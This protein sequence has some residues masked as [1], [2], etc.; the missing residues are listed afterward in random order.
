MSL[1]WPLSRDGNLSF[2]FTWGDG[3]IEDRAKV[4][5]LPLFE[6]SMSPLFEGSSI[7]NN[8]LRDNS[9][10]TKCMAMQTW[11]EIKRQDY[12][13]RD[14]YGTGLLADFLFL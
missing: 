13:L 4:S 3:K 14:I 6:G 12:E 10:R 1:R 8:E 2:I 5:M 9:T 11:F 7:N